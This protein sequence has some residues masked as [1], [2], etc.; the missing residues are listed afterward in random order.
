MTPFPGVRPAAPAARVQSCVRAL[1]TSEMRPGLRLVC[2]PYAGGGAYQYRAWATSLSPDVGVFAVQLP[3]RED[4]IR[5]QPFS[6][7]DDA[8]TA[9]TQDLVAVL[10]GPFAIFGHSLGAIIGAEVAFRLELERAMRPEHLF[11]SGCRGLP[12]VNVDRRPVHDLPD[13]ELLDHVRRLN[14]THEELLADDTIRAFMLRLI[15]AD[16]AM[17]DGYTY[18]EDRTL[19]CPVTAFGGEA[20]PTVAPATLT[21]WSAVT[22]GPFDVHVLRGDHFFLHSTR[23]EL[24]MLLRAALKR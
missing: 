5:E 3:G 15:R 9:V 11:V 21:A 14:G 18:T 8:V 2:F 1:R 17:F 6:A 19:S 24:L 7:L 12:V 22:T 20:D 13:D 4:R 16:Y 23:D 10:D